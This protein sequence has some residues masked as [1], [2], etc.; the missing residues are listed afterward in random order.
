MNTKLYRKL[1]IDDY[2]LSLFAGAYTPD[3]REGIC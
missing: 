2:T 1:Y 3:K